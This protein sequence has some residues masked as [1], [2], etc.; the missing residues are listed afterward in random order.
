MQGTDGNLYGTTSGG[1]PHGYCGYP[2]PVGGT[3]FKITPAGIL[4]TLYSFCSTT[5]CTD[6]DGPY[7]ELVQATDGNFYG[8]T[9]GGGG[10]GYCGGLGCG[11]VFEIT[12]AG[13]LTTL[14]ELLLSSRIALMAYFLTQAVCRKMNG[15]FYGITYQGGANG[16]GTVFSLSVNLQSHSLQFVPVTPCRLVDTRNPD[17]EFGGPPI[18]GGTFR[19]FPIPDNLNCGIPNTAGAYSLNVTVVPHESLGYLTIWPAGQQQPLVST[20]NSLDGRVKAN[21]AIVLA[22]GNGAVSVF[23]SDTTDVVLDIDGYFT[24]AGS[25]TLTFYPLSPCRVA[26]TRNPDGWLG[27]P[28]LQ[29]WS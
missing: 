5:N 8:T 12:H 1:G 15:N 3:V 29:G 10:H 28:Y 25:T 27:G 11:T 4:T 6:G 22:G 9:N 18:Q 20:L 2:I 24:P 19:N 26:D 7:G 23:A 16:S 21:A 13:T 17:G 14:Y